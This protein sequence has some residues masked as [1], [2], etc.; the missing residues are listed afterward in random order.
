MNRI[1]FSD[2][3]ILLQADALEGLRALS[4]HCAHVCV[5]FPPYYGLRDY[6]ME[7]QMGMEGFCSRVPPLP[8]C[9][10]SG[11]QPKNREQRRTSAGKLPHFLRKIRNHPAFIFSL[12]PSLCVQLTPQGTNVLMKVTVSRTGI[13]RSI[14]EDEWKNIQAPFVRPDW[15]TVHGLRR[16]EWL[17]IGGCPFPSDYSFWLSCF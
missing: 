16:G 9:V 6:G 7:G 8:W 12:I 3:G 1:D 17:K 13:N 4:D 15:S 10:F 14:P 5:T 11:K 2:V